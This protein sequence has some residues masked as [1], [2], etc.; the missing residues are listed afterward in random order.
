MAAKV[1]SQTASRLEVAT[2]SGA[3]E[4]G[5]GGRPTS[6]P[7][8]PVATLSG[9]AGGERKARGKSPAPTAAAET[10]QAV[11][12]STKR[13]P[14]AGALATLSGASNPPGSSVTLSGTERTR[15]PKEPSA[16]EK[17]DA[18]IAAQTTQKSVQESGAELFRVALAKAGAKTRPRPP[19]GAGAPA[20]LPPVVVHSPPATLSGAGTG[21]AATRATATTQNGVV[22][23]FCLRRRC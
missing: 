16:D 11:K 3:T 14:S 13:S 22:E 7:P 2:L 8:A 6:S 4:S 23:G 9:A 5:R 20:A 10:A 1:K 12:R 17:L 18:L 21:T 15:S 19:V